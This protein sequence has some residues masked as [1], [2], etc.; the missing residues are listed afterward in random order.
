MDELNLKVA[1]TVK[2]WREQDGVKLS[3]N[4]PIDHNVVSLNLAADVEAG[5]KHYEKQGWH[6]VE[7]KPEA[8]KVDPVK[9]ND[10]VQKGQSESK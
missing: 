7:S 10:E 8:K 1:P 9:K 6:R 2:V 3:A 4:M 5:I